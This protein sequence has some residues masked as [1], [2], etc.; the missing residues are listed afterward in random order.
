M[1]FFGVNTWGTIGPAMLALRTGAPI[2]PASVIRARDGTYKLHVH[3]P[4]LATRE[5]AFRDDLV[6]ITQRCQDSIEAMI[7]AHPGQWLWFHRRWKP[8]PRLER[9]WSDK[10]KP[11]PTT[12]NAAVETEAR[13][14]E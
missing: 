12:G 6:R 13:H 7:R 10:Q 9:E 1:T 2:Y 8:R 3:P 4:I 11:Q 14:G 5:G